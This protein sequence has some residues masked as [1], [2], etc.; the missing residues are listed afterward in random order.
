MPAVIDSIC[1]DQS[2]NIDSLNEE[3][4]RMATVGVMNE[5]PVSEQKVIA[6]CVKNR[7]VIKVLLNVISAK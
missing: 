7:R 3:W 4:R 1:K 2:I 6:Q 5:K